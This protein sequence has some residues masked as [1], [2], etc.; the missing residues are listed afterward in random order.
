VLSPA[1]F[2]AG[3]AD[4]GY[5]TAMDVRFA[6]GAFEEPG[7]AAAWLR[8]AV[9][10]VAGEEPSPLVRVLAAA[11]S[12]NGISAVASPEALLFINTDLTVALHRLPRGEWVLL[13]ARTVLEPHGIG[14]ATSRLHDLDG[15]LGVA[16]QT[17][18]VAPR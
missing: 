9:P 4:V 13:D 10:L 7:P 2:F 3:A 15:A 8:M 1:P 16:V 18:F 17:L 11:D 14:Q 6:A 5:H 12:G